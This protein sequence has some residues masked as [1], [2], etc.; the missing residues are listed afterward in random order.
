MTEPVLSS[1][2]GMNPPNP[3]LAVM[4]GNLELE[5]FN[6]SLDGDFFTKLFVTSGMELRLLNLKLLLFR[7]VLVLTSPLPSLAL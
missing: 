7:L 1:F 4:S 2:A 3:V 5:P 6:L